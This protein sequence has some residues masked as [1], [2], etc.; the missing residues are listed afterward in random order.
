MAR[1][2]L[3]GIGAPRSGTTWLYKLLR[4]H[5]DI[6]LPSVVKEIHFFDR[7]NRSIEWYKDFFK[8][9]YNYTWACEI[10]PEY[11]SME[12]NK[13]SYIKENLSKDLKSILI[14]RNP[15]ERLK[16]NY[17]NSILNNKFTGSF[18][19]YITN[20]K[21]NAVDK[22]LYHKHI[23]KWLEFFPRKNLLILFFDD[24]IENPN[25]VINKIS[26]FLNVNHE[27]FSMPDK[28]NSSKIP[29]DF[30]QNI[31]KIGVRFDR[32]LKNRNFYKTSKIVIKIGRILKRKSK[33]KQIKFNINKKT[34][35]YLKKLYN[36][37]IEM[38]E[39]LIN[40]DLSHWKK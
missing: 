30:F 16:S 9:S 18:E 29:S 1:P 21:G 12:R 7:S 35:D 11:Y 39:K 32:F 31:F 40:K 27:E 37:D 36:P 20:N 8:N 28:T 15:Y 26:D 3:L 23:V 38:L 10:T 5:P 6:Y 17:K 22:G 33:S 14:L 34:E 25:E 24:I 2:N 19:D 13:L 4:S